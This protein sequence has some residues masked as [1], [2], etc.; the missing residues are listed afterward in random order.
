MH[1][2]ALINHKDLTGV[3]V[4]DAKSNDTNFDIYK[5]LLGTVNSAGKTPVDFAA[6][7]KTTH[8]KEL[9][10]LLYSDEQLTEVVKT[11]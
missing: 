6:K 9:I 8:F 4:D 1:Y 11:E 10:D 2:L 7:F 3:L 5:K